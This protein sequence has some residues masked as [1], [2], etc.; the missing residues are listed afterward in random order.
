M[1]VIVA[2]DETHT[3][4]ALTLLL[5]RNGF[6]VTSFEDGARALEKV[7]EQTAT[8]EP[9]DLLVID[10]EMPGVTGIEVLEA[11]EKLGLRLPVLAISGSEARGPLAARSRQGG[12]WFLEKPFGPEEFL[13]SVSGVIDVARRVHGKERSVAATS[14]EPCW[15]DR[16]DERCTPNGAMRRR[17]R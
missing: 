3:L 6:R 15:A 11:I 1:N 7:L 2:D 13:S 5:E 17:Q 16:G 8:G 12:V 4:L 14:P 10:I 9:V